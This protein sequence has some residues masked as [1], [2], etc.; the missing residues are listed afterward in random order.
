MYFKNL[1]KFEYSFPGVS[2]VE[3]QDIFRRV[4]F[5][6]NTLKDKRN[7]E[8]YLIVQGEKPDDVSQKF[9][10]T[11][12]YWWLVLLC[13]NIIDTENEWPKAV[14]EIDNLFSNFLTGNSYY[15]MENLDAKEG[16]ILVKRDTISIADA[17]THGGTAGID[18]DHYGIIDKYDPILRKIDVKISEG[19]LNKGDE[20]HIFRKGVTGQ[21]VSIS[22]FGETGCYQ[23]YFGAT[24][25]VEITG[26]T[27]SLVHGGEWG[28]MC[29]SQGS[30]FGIIQKKDSIR[31]SVKEFRYEG[32]PAN[33]Y[34]SFI[35]GIE[36]QDDGMSGEFF[37]YQSLCGM[38]GTI[39]FDYITD[40][41]S[42]NVNV[43]T[44]GDDI[45]NTND[46]NRIIQLLTPKL[47]GLVRTEISMLLKGNVPRG[48]TRMVELK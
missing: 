40:S 16:D 38:T 4:V 22:G 32:N 10:G 15:L 36:N 23:A 5:T 31:D 45:F 6:E 19:T 2:G 47:V 30:S 26:P 12:D 9:Y 24:S 44:I 17:L 37:S 14:S 21:Y 11:P 27:G 33:P 48:T 20:V 13:N 34:S 43:V 18:I 28:K 39:L 41:L 7:F 1:P 35:S 42:E 3:L 29:A 25:C 46:R 8:D